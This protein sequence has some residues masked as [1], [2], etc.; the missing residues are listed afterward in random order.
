VIYREALA[1]DERLVSAWINMGNA[2]AKQRQF[3]EAHGAYDKALTL[4]PSDPRVKDVIDELRAIERAEGVT[5]AVPKD[6][7]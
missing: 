2:F 3:V 7:P 5:P 1:L 4:D 6:K